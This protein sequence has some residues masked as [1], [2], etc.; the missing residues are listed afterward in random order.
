MVSQE[1]MEKAQTVLQQ[2]QTDWLRREGVTA[3]DLG[4]KWSGGK[5]SDQLAIRVHV[6]QKIVPEA[7]TEMDLFP[8]ELDGIPVDIIEA[9]YNIQ[10]VVESEGEAAQL[11]TAVDGRG[12]RFAEI[13]L[14]VS[15]GSPKVTAGTLGAKVFDANTH[16]AM[17]LSN[18]HVMV[19]SL[20]AQ[21]GD[22]VWQPGQLD[23]GNA[24]DVIAHISRWVLGPFDAAVAKVSENRPVLAQ[25]IENKEISDLLAPR[26]GMTVWKSGRTTGY[27]EGFVDGIMMSTSLNYR[28]AGVRELRAVF[29]IVPR[30][31]APTTE[32]SLG[33]D[34]GSI[35]VDKTSGKAVGLHFAGETG[36]DPEFAL[37]HDIIS[38][39]DH[40]G[41]LFPAQLPIEPTQP[42]PVVDPITPPPPVDPVV[43]PAPVEPDPPVAIDP[44]PLPPP[45]T[46][47][48]SFWEVLLRFFRNLFK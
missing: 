16:E 17:I 48:P 45:P 36:D 21:A 10:M 1:D 9:T 40:L 35:W 43:D 12:E 3:V 18:W 39:T 33:G 23:G 28:T 42:D 34:S 7:L 44:I 14:G 27:T 13:P 41:V 26:L 19:G 6:A 15:I 25:T 8:K 37:A 4:F 31:E 24:G 2:V 38:V 5:M 47:S 29:R 11:E 46:K 22:P 30:P 32:V 20:N